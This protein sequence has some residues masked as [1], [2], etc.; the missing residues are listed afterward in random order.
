[1]KKKL[2][3]GLGACLCISLLGCGA[4]NQEEESSRRNHGSRTEEDSDKD[5]D[6]DKKKDKEDKD[7][8]KED[9]D[10]DKD[11]D[12][13]D[14]DKEKEDENKEKED[15][16][17]KDKDKEEKDKEKED[18][19]DEDKD[20]KE[21]EDSKP[22][23]KKSAKLSD[24]LYDA[25]IEIDG[26]VITL[27]CMFDDIEDIGLKYNGDADSKMLPSNYMTFAEVFKSDDMTIYAG[28]INFDVN[29]QAFS[30]CMAFQFKVEEGNIKNNSVDVK[31]A[32]DIQ[33]SVSTL[34]DVIEAYGQPNDI[35]N[36][37]Y[38]TRYTYNENNDCEIELSF[39]VDTDILS[40]IEIEHRVKPDDFVEGEVST[41]IPAITAAYTA[42]KKLGDDLLSFN[43]EFDGDMYTL[44]VPVSEFLDNGWKFTGSEA[45]QI[46]DGSGYMKIEMQKGSQSFWTFV[47]NYSQS[48]TAVENC[49]VTKIEAGEYTCDVDMT[50]PDGIYKGMSQKELEKILIDYKYTV[51]DSSSSF[52]YY[53][54]E[55]DGYGHTVEL[56]V[57]K[58][59]KK[60]TIIEIENSPKINELEE[61][62][63]IK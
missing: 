4:V 23:S 46:V 35:Y 29:E 24:D 52:T 41:D 34:D 37:T 19:D 60:V 50:L 28:L 36:G 9:K 59:S 2:L 62:Y 16:E 49:F 1:M 58:E 21:D 5:S 44:P 32:K 56:V 54:V 18:K 22:S 55:G 42:P 45:G 51:D 15:K 57:N 40:S 30:D 10:K 53:T 13:E 38:Y 7:K 27:P 6:R 8:E 25:Q 39:D 63:G 31:M 11:K 47:E 48:A 26:T 14:K 12:K 20:K 43:F 17:D 3:L 61:Q 33:L